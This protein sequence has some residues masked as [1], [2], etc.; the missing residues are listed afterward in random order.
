MIAISNRGMK[1]HLFWETLFHELAHLLME[2]KRVFLFNLNGNED[3]EAESIM[4]D[5]LIPKKEYE[6]FVNKEEFNK[7][8]ILEFAS[9]IEV[10]PSIVLERLHKEKRKIKDYKNLEKF[11]HSSYEI[12]IKKAKGE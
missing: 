2:H 10:L 5:L 7:E 8:S 9:K 4:N 12:T 3:I 1:A 6:E 11:F